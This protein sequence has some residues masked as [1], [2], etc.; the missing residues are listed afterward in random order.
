MNDRFK[1]RVWDTVGD[2]YCPRSHY[3]LLSDGT[4]IEEI[5]GEDVICDSKNIEFCTGL[6]DKN[7]RLIYEG[8]IVEEHFLG[9]RTF[10]VKWLD[11][12][13]G[14]NISKTSYYNDGK[15]R[16]TKDNEYEIVANI[17]ENMELLK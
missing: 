2:C 3:I 10:I 5:G 6:K 12:H 7:G 8:D 14:F 4:L 9:T 1:F 16:F 15:V 17:H 11:D 13:C